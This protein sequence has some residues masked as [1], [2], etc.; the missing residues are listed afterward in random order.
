MNA[1]HECKMGLS[2]SIQADDCH[3]P[4]HLLGWKTQARA[5]ASNT[6]QRWEDSPEVSVSF[7][8]SGFGIPARELS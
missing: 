4:N 8:R 1:M 6:R 2:C 7:S 5:E 3:F